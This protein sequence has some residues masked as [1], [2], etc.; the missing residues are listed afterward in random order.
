[1]WSSMSSLSLIVVCD[2]RQH[3]R[4]HYR[5]H[6]QGSW[7]FENSVENE[8]VG[9]SSLVH[10]RAESHIAKKAKN[11]KKWQKIGGLLQL[12]REVNE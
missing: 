5:Q 8:V 11:G 9:A 7:K 2:H 1:M 4:Q 12:S 10:S 6:C 3:Y